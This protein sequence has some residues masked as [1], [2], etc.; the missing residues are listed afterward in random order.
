MPRLRGKDLKRNGIGVPMPSVTELI[1][2][3]FGDEPSYRLQS[4]MAHGHPWALQRLG[5]RL[6]E[7]DDGIS[8]YVKLRQHITPTVVGYLSTR[9]VRAWVRPV[10][11]KCRQNGWDMARLR[12]ILESS[13]DAMRLV[14][15]E[16][17]WRIGPAAPTS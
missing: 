13:Y 7:N 4:A 12:A 5:Y 3:L 6:D 11:Y 1:A 9:S 8:G 2:R 15:K 14:E 17:F 16:R 10:W